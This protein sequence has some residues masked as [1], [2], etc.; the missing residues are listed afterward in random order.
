[1]SQVS[2]STRGRGYSRHGISTR[3]GIFFGGVQCR[4]GHTV[5]ASSSFF[6]RW[7]GA[8]NRDGTFQPAVNYEMPEGSN[9]AQGIVAGDFNGDGSPDDVLANDTSANLSVLLNTGGTLMRTTSSVNPSKVGQSVTFTT[10][11]KASLSGTGTPTGTVTF[12]DGSKSIKV[13][14]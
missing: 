6:A 10:Q 11:V 4:G 9:Y 8:G 3:P 13:S 14:L 5:V 7:E 2:S 1:M 12:K